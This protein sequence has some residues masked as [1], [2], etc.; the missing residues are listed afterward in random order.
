MSSKQMQQVSSCFFGLIFVIDCR[1]S[2]TV[3]R[4][5][6]LRLVTFIWSSFVGL[7]WN[8]SLH[9]SPEFY[10]CTYSDSRMELE[11]LILL[12]SFKTFS[13][14]VTVMRLLLTW[15]FLREVYGIVSPPWFYLG[16]SECSESV[17]S[18]CFLVLLRGL[19]LL[20]F[21]LTNRG[22]SKSSIWRRS[23]SSET[24]FV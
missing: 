1:F 8:S 21:W 17:A 20:T 6:P 23:N 19:C 22:E 4:N 15:R 18:N 7:L 24:S 11:I 14:S 2:S 12:S 5:F 10:I 13:S 9:S 3:L 16:S